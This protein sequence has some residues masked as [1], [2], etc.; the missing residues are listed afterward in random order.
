MRPQSKRLAPAFSEKGEKERIS[1]LSLKKKPGPR[2]EINAKGISRKGRAHAFL[3][4]KTRKNTLVEYFCSQ[5][6]STNGTQPAPN[7]K[8]R[9]EP[10]P[11][12]AEHFTGLKTASPPL[13]KE[14]RTE[15]GRSSSQGIE[16]TTGAS[17]AKEDKNSTPHPREKTKQKRRK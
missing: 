8:Q 7:K 11:R 5:P 4:Q 10:G 15:S 1:G 14:S 3:S 13:K 12:N 9:E 17:I 16:G 6:Q 2:Q